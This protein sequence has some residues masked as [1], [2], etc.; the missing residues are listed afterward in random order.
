MSTESSFG[1]RPEP[2]E[3]R[4]PSRSPDTA[5]WHDPGPPVK[6]VSLPPDLPGTGVPVENPETHNPEKHDE[7]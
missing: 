2:G 7:T 3:P 5:P 1:E 6:K 4:E